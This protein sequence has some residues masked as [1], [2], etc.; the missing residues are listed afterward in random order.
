MRPFS[1]TMMLTSIVAAII[2]SGCK[3]DTPEPTPITPV[4]PT[5]TIASLSAFFSDQ[6][7]QSQ[8]F[9]I[10][11][12]S[13]QT[14]TG[15]NGTIVGFGANTFVTMSGAPVTGN[16][17]IE[18]REI[19]D[20]KTMLLSNVTSNGEHYPG[21]PQ[22][23]LISGGEFYVHAKQGSADLKLAPGRTYNVFLPNANPNP[24]M[25]LFDGRVD[26]DTAIWAPN[27]D[28]STSIVLPQLPAPQG[29]FATCDSLDWGN[30]DCFMNSPNYTN[31]IMNI[32][33]T[34]DPQQIQAFVWYDNV[35]VLWSCWSSFNSITNTYSDSHTAAGLPVHLIVISV[36]DG[37]LYRAILGTTSSL[38]G[39]Y[40]LTM[41]QSDE[42]TFKNEL[43]ALQ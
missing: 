36:K 11:N 27:L 41:T 23:P 24:N 18:L 40:N 2:F 4:T 7:A 43:A 25:V 32:S 1:K 38:N 37:V 15:S 19:Y 8:F 16:I 26:E 13:T 42:T 21:G 22:E 3:K 34:F 20:K 30:A 33:G 39:V 10:S 6:G 9:T 29:Y 14:I 28:S 31:I 12:N 35:N 17:T 5:P